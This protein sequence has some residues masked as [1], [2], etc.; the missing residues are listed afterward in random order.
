MNDV[1]LTLSKLADPAST[2]GRQNLT[3][4][5]LVED[6]HQ[7]NA[8][9]GTDLEGSLATYRQI[10]GKVKHRHNK[11]LAHYDL[12]TL[13]TAR[14]T[15]TPGPSRQEIEDALG[16]LR[17]F[18]NALQRPFTDAVTA[19]SEFVLTTDGD[20]L[21]SVLKQGLRYGELVDSS[22]VHWDDLRQNSKYFGV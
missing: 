20:Q 11:Q 16:E 19:Y 2:F 8:K 10:C 9:L 6:V 18:M 22:A 1:Q 3:L 7:I 14:S 12:A 13:M 5:S 4:E 21:L 17:N 15:P